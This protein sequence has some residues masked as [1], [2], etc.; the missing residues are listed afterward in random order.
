MTRRALPLLLAAAAL[1]PGTEALAAP[2][3][4]PVPPRVVSA[5]YY[6]FSVNGVGSVTWR[7][8]IQGAL[9]GDGGVGGVAVPLKDGDVAVAATTSDASGETAGG[10][11]IFFNS[12]GAR[13]LQVYFCGTLP[14]TRI[15][16]GAAAAER[17]LDPAACPGPMTTGTVRF[18]LAQR[19]PKR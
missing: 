9:V 11:L 1:L 10:G 14:S 8:G 19:Q 5:T 18:T 16:V 13:M 17:S 3:P 2:K 12:S 7:G 4:R 6:G 15:P